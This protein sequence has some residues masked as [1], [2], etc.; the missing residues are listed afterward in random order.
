MSLCWLCNEKWCLTPT[1]LLSHPSYVFSSFPCPRPPQWLLILTSKPMELNLRC[2]RQ[3]KH[4]SWKMYWMTFLWPWPKVMAVALINN[5]FL[6]CRIKWEPLN[7]S[8]QNILPDWILEEFCWELCFWQIFFENFGCVFFK[9][10]HYCTYLRNGWFDW[11]GTKRRHISW[12]LGELC[13]LDLW[14]HPWPW[15]LI[16]QGQISK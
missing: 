5:N 10:K 8:L 11:C 14:P 16:F 6:V 9:V 2:L 4:R 7:Q 12:I 13:D 1:N 3:R 15:P